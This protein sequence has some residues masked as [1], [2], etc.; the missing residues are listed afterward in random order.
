VPLLEYVVT[1]MIVVGTPDV[2]DGALEPGTELL[3][4]PVTGLA[5]V[6]LAVPPDDMDPGMLL[7]EGVSMP[8]GTV[9][10]TGTTSVSENVVYGRVTGTVMV[11]E[12]TMVVVP[13][14]E[15]LE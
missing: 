10:V 4:D 7:D 12:I 1:E 6:L 5:G 13:S 8:S 2:A 3:S 14:V 9:R 15:E 11:S